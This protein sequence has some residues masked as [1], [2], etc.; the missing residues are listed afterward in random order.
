MKNFNFPPKVAKKLKEKYSKAS[1]RDIKIAFSGAILYFTLC[2]KYKDNNIP[3]PSVVVDDI[4]HEFIL[5]TKDYEKF[6][7]KYLG[8]FLHHI[9][10]DEEK[11]ID[12][13]TSKEQIL[14]L[15]IIACQEEGYEPTSST[16]KPSLF[17]ADVLFKER[18]ES[19]I[20]GLAQEVK[21]QVLNKNR[22]QKENWMSM[23]KKS[24]GLTAATKASDAI[25][26]NF[27][28]NNL[29]TTVYFVD[30]EPVRRSNSVVDSGS[31]VIH[32]D[33]SSSKNH[34]SHS[35]HSKHSCG[36]STDHSTSTHS[37]SSHT[38]S[39]GGCG[40]GGD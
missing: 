18:S 11:P 28:F 2:K 34:D 30:D 33:N 31:T 5:H 29:L 17:Y 27:D 36:S 22:P 19:Y 39:C 21:R 14:S 12:K 20:E 37:C 24:V 15:W 16:A 4:W 38:S 23:L 1:S 8:F 32:S 35:S 7:E 40:G 10:N 9:P 6:C 26:G 13:K 25:A 3:M